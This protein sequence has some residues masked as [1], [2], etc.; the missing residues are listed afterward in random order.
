M[1]DTDIRKKHLPLSEAA[2]D[3]QGQDLTSP[4]S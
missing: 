4:Q 1:F 3:Q 2:S